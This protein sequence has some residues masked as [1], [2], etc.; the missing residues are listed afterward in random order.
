[1]NYPFWDVPVIGG[2]WV[3]GII[4]IFHMMISHFAVG[5]GFYLP[6]DRTQGSQGRPRGLA[7]DVAAIPASS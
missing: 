4:A 3:I 5:G 6:T 2:A 7:G 1:M